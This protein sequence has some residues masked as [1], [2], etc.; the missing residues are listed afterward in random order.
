MVQTEYKTT[1]TLFRPLL[2]T[3]LVHIAL[4]T[5]VSVEQDARLWR[6]CYGGAG[7]SEG[8]SGC[9]EQGLELHKDPSAND[10]RFL[11]MRKLKS[12]IADAL[13]Q[14][15]GL[16]GPGSIWMPPHISLS[17]HANMLTV[18][19]GLRGWSKCGEE[20][21]GGLQPP[22]G[23]DGHPVTPSSGTCCETLTVPFALDPWTDPEVRSLQTRL[24]LTAFQSLQVLP[25]VWPYRVLWSFCGYFNLFFVKSC[26]LP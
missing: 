2:K 13:F 22:W 21:W 4:W 25:T 17:R 14:S 19:R 23:W 11:F 15:T 10:Y 24:N 6:T 7:G 1:G 9:W 18:P 3:A 26:Y 20:L 5:L 8:A 16:Q 12:H